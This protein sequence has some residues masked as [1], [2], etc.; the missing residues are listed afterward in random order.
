MIAVT[1][2]SGQLGRHV[3]ETLLKSVPA[4]SIV[5]V[6][7]DP[8]KVS[9]FAEKGVVVRQADYDAPGTLEPALQGV[10]KLLMISASEIG[11]RVPQHRAVIDAA[12]AAGVGLIA[13]TSILKCDTSPLTLAVEHKETEALLE[14]SGVPYVLLRN[15]WYGENYLGAI[16]AA[17]EHGALFGC[18]GEGRLSFAARRDFA[19]AAAAVLVKDDQAGKVYELAGDSAISLA[20]LAGLISEN[21]GRTIPYTDIPESAYKD[22]LVGAGLPEPVA[23]MLADSE[24]GASK[25][26]LQHDGGELSALIGRPTTPMSELVATAMKG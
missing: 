14:A 18:A 5:A 4:E 20:D 19:E 21:A 25:G 10:D 26:A 24:T 11:R 8:S 12:R 23:A 2:A 15:G 1:G 17:L 3:V 13:Y 7:R 16:P 6:V 22:A 9:D